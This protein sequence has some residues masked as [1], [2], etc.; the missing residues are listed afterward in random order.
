MVGQAKHGAE[1]MIRD[2]F[3]TDERGEVIQ[4]LSR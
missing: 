1:E 4:N 2:H 3:G